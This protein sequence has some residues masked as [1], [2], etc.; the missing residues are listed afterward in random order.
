M[1]GK[2]LLDDMWSQKRKGG[3]SRLGMLQLS[4]IFLNLSMYY[5]VLSFLH[6]LFFELSP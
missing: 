1:I 6:K 3:K 5:V 4:K 2:I